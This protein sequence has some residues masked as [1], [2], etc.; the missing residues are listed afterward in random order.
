LSSTSRPPLTPW[1]EEKLKADA[2]LEAK[3]RVKHRVGRYARWKE[4]YRPDPVGFVVENIRF[5][6]GEEP[7]PYQCEALG[8]LLERGRISLRGP[9]GLGKTALAAWLVLWFALVWDGEDWKVPTTASA[10]RQLTK[11]LWP[12]IHKWARRIDWPKVGR[13]PLSEQRE[14]LRLSL[15]LRTGEAFA[16]ASS[17]PNA[18]EGAHA[19]H[20]LYVFDE[21]KRLDVN[22]L[23]PTPG[24][25][26]TMGEI[27]VGD[28]VLDEM[29]KP[30]AVTYVS[31][32]L[33]DRP[34]VK[35]VFNDGSELVADPGH[36]WATLP[37]RR[38]QSWGQRHAN[39]VRYKRKYER[40]KDWREYWD[41]AD[42][43]ETR[44]LTEG[45][46]RQA[47]PT[48]LPLDLPEKDLPID[49]YI[50]GAWLGDGSSYHAV[51]TS[52][53]EDMLDRIAADGHELTLR[54]TSGKAGTYGMV[55]GGLQAALREL[56]LLENKHI[57]SEYLRASKKQRLALLRGLMDTDG[58]VM[59]E[60]G[61]RDSRVSFSNTNR[62]L[63]QGVAELVKAFGWKTKITETMGKYG[64]KETRPVY[65]LRWSADICPFFIKRKADAWVP[66]EVQASRSTIRTVV[67]VE[68]VSSVPTRC[69]SVD[70]ERH[71]YLAGKD[72]IPTHNSI[73]DE[74]WNSAEGAFA[75]PDKGEALALAISTPGEPKGRFY[76]IHRRA[77]GLEN[78]WAR[79]VTLEE[80][81]EAGRI[82]QEWVENAKDLWGED[83]PLYKTRVLGEFAEVDEEG[84]IPLSWVEAANDRWRDWAERGKPLPGGLTAV[85]VDVA[86][87]GEDKTVYALRHGQILTSIRRTVQEDTMQTTGRVI[88]ILK[89][90]GR[91]VVDVI[92][93][94]AG[95][96][97]R[98]REKKQKVVAFNAARKSLR[99]DRSGELGFANWRAEAWWSMRELLED[100]EIA[101]PPDDLLI[102]DLTAPR[103]KVQSGGK[104]Q[105][106]SKDELR[107]AKRLG[108]SPD[109]GDAVV[110]A[111]WKQPG[112]G[113]WR[114]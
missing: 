48:C 77:P 52:M 26:T 10:W 69:I 51:I 7:T 43:V 99:L 66:R 87:T 84:V 59:S 114:G 41:K 50:L 91:A 24:G 39:D 109:T 57:P 60:K 89:K 92:G 45:K 64:G 65:I 42:I 53:D 6:P 40:V 98:L 67:S 85:G 86:R 16:L 75:S 106:E 72:F 108:R 56:G 1:A 111:F 4:R 101:L 54:D 31:P 74:I 93:V 103:W 90:G 70:S 28:I 44:R 97:D 102:G 83:S 61:K 30:T 68:P 95:V 36:L 11:Y 76:E 8:Q 18:I 112:G 2:W 80:A 71:L 12:E 73:P 19:K 5:A 94:G 78:W 38:R 96:V 55:R 13:E 25:W 17:D 15:K 63:V 113:V 46:G 33:R 47:I 21:A 9:H 37:Y 81:M 104:I 32:V 107:K 14:L 3:R 23:I 88:G 29:G 22:T 20:L 58:T 105:I 110:M 27:E 49:P 62:E 35:V 34:C 79:H 100:G 82:G